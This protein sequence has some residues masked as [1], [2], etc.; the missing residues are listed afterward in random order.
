M[1]LLFLYIEMMIIDFIRGVCVC[2]PGDSWSW[3]ACASPLQQGPVCTE[4][5]VLFGSH[6]PES[7]VC[8]HATRWTGNC[9]LNDITQGAFVC[10][11]LHATASSQVG[12]SS[13]HK[14]CKKTHAISLSFPCRDSCGDL[15]TVPH[16]IGDHLRF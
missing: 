2:V 1:Q 6:L 10:F 11:L 14:R 3:G 7:K 9:A 5:S 8:A 16:F 4:V 13:S 12:C 15:H